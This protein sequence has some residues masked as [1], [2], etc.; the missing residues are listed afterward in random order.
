M[1]ATPGAVVPTGSF[2][3]FRGPC[4]FAVGCVSRLQLG[5]LVPALGDLAV[6]VVASGCEQLA[7]SSFV[8]LYACHPLGHP[9]LATPSSAGK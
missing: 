5:W 2:P 4:C 8:Y 9:A 7:L 6:C 3:L 1:R